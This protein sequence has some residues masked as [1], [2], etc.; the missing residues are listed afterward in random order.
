MT[1]ALLR[2]RVNP[3]SSRNQITGWQDGELSIKL[4]APPVEGA[5]NKACIEFLADILHVKKSQIT[6]VSGATGRGKVF[7]IAG[8]SD[9]DITCRLSTNKT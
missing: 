3:R 5:A 8:L 4:T 9:D 1:K 7:E 6:M 2:V